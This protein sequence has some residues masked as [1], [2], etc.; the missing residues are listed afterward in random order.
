MPLV[1]SS[2]TDSFINVL[3]R[4][5]YNQK[6]ATALIS[7]A[8]IPTRASF[9]MFGDLLVHA[10]GHKMHFLPS[11]FPPPADTV[12]GTAAVVASASAA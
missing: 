12:V 7:A 1:S 5:Y 11:E 2:T 6:E 3:K 9:N 10:R 8:Y 4:K